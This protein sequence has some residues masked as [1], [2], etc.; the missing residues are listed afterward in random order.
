VVVDQEM[1]IGSED[2]GG[3]DP[4]ER[5]LAERGDGEERCEFRGE[6][7]W[8]QIHAVRHD[9]ENMKGCEPAVDGRL[10]A[11]PLC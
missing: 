10:A 2:I 8:R 4:R 1:L 5:G 11:G 6:R 3:G 9:E 7:G